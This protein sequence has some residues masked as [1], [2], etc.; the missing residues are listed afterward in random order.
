MGS[1]HKKISISFIRQL[2][3]FDE[4]LRFW[5]G[6]NPNDHGAELNK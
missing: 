3:V 4:I 5:S 6:Y 2:F 1:F